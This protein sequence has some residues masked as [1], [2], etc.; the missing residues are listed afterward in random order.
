MLNKRRLVF[1]LFFI[2]FINCA[3]PTDQEPKT[4]TPITSISS[5][6]QVK[7]CLYRYAETPYQPHQEVKLDIF[8]Y[9]KSIN[10]YDT[11]GFFYKWSTFPHR[12][13][14]INDTT[15]ALSAIEY[16][17]SDSNYIEINLRFIS[18]INFTHSTTYNLK[19]GLDDST[20]LYFQ[21][22]TPEANLD[23]LIYPDSISHGD[24]IC[25][26]W[27]QPA[28]SN[29]LYL[30][31]YNKCVGPL[32]TIY[33]CSNSA[34]LTM[35]YGNTSYTIPAALLNSTIGYRISFFSNRTGIIDSSLAAGS[36]IQAIFYN[37]RTIYLR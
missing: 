37:D 4:T 22:R 28:P 32:G 3:N 30:I 31:V 1:G 33:E 7:I 5:G 18:G 34:T 14:T 36:V 23:S 20:C 19:Y 2:F 11:T 35:P 16:N 29:D 17:T 21:I 27:T 10:I 15:Y 12:Y 8:D 26:N 6:K 25:L 24:P 9:D 13:L